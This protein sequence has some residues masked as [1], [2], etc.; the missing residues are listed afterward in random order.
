VTLSDTPSS[1]GQPQS[2]VRPLGRPNPDWDLY[3]IVIS[4][5]VDSESVTSRVTGYSMILVPHRQLPMMSWLG[6]E[7][8]VES[9]NVAQAE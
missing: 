9:S 7:S 4:A 2:I 3:L 1:I 5:S 6:P 8:V